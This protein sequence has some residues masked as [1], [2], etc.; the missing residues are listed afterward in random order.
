MRRFFQSVLVLLT[1]LSA[2]GLNSAWAAEAVRKH[3]PWATFSPGAWQQVQVFTQVFNKDGNV[4]DTGVTEEKTMLE[5]VDDK[6]VTL[7]TKKSVWVAGKL[8][9]REPESTKQGIYGESEGQKATIKDLKPETLIIEGSKIP[10]TVREV[11]VDDPKSKILQVSKLYFNDD[12]APFVLKRT[13]TITKQGEK[14]VLSET[15]MSVDALQMPCL[16]SEGLCSAAHYRST[17]KHA[18]G[19]TVT[20]GYTSPEVPGG[21]ICQ[22]TKELDRENRLV[23]RS[24]I[25]LTDYDLKPASEE[26]RR[27]L[28]PG[29]FRDS[30]PRATRRNPS[31]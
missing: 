27:R 3:N 9:D 13:T 12:V 14:T 1:V 30:R 20:L 16:A 15:S 2:V 31:E 26:R 19:T 17:T 28:F 23:R 8:L 24:V 4:V 22:C 7:Q 6:G 11:R 18:L 10:C 25:E 5:K 21:V 29:R